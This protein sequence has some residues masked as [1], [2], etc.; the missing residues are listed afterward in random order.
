MGSIYSN[1]PKAEYMVVNP[2]SL[3]ILKQQKE[4]H[5]GISLNTY[6]IYSTNLASLPDFIDTAQ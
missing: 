5:Y 4:I 1:G 3:K 6:W 2:Y